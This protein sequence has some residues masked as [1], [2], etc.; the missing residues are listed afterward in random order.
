MKLKTNICKICK[1]EK[2]IDEFYFRDNGKRIHSECKCCTKKKLGI[3]NID[4][5]NIAEKN[6]KLGLR[7]CSSCK[8]L[9]DIKK[10]QKRKNNNRNSICNFCMQKRTK[11]YI[12]KQ[13]KEVGNFYAKQFAITNYKIKDKKNIPKEI[14]EIAKEHIKIK[15]AILYKID[16]KEFKTKTSFAKYVSNKY[17]SPFSGIFYRLKNGASLND[18]C[19]PEKEYRS[20]RSKGKIK[21]T[22]LVTKQIFVFEKQTSL[23]LRR[24]FS[25]SCITRC[26]KYKKPT[27]PIKYSKYKNPCKIERI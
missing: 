12:N 8:K 18:C 25:G 11:K 17:K 3:K 20:K 13:R 10:F 14:I 1:K 4:K 5:Y 16:G 15:R 9:I 24:M 27:Q 19:M 21:V 23:D 22:D 26:I 2:L 7:R 6:K